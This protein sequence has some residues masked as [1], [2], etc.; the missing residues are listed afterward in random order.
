M[1]V[2]PLA[3]LAGSLVRS[4]TG[5]LGCVRAAAAAAA[6]AADRNGRRNGPRLSADAAHSGEINATE[7][8][9]IN[10]RICHAP[11]LSLSL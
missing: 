1:A 9:R 2:G 10:C 7:R 5:R 3:I 4:F 6:R 8:S 11:N